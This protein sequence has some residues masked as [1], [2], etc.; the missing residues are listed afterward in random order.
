MNDR[1]RMSL[2]DYV[3]ELTRPYQHTE[4]IQTRGR[5]GT[6]YGHNHTVAVPSLL[7]QLW[8]NDT[9]SGA[10]EE[11]PRP[12]YQSK[13]AAR[14][15]ALDT[16][17]RI[18]IEAS[19]WITDLGDQPRT[20]NTADLILQL[21]GLQASSADEQRREI[22][23][24][25]RRWW[26]RA[27]IV[28]GW[29]SPAWTPDATCPQCGVRG[30]LRIRLADHIGMCTKDECRAVWGEETIGI[31]ADHIRVETSE[32]RVR[33]PGRGPCYCPWPEPAV[34]DLSVLC[35]R[36]GSARCRHALERRLLAAVSQAS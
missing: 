34:P 3:H 5:D 6:W 28:T 11:G 31:L 21:H 1:Q 2:A 33:A 15:D 23:R 22:G 13:P 7:Q 24:D 30:T 29:D 14:L 19:R 32:A 20:T 18:D 35:P 4:H 26:I 8:D 12:G 25:V 10:A 17:A 16:A 36:C 27:R 9:P